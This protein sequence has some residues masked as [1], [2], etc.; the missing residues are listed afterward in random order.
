[1]EGRAATIIA[2]SPPVSWRSFSEWQ[3]LLNAASESPPPSVRPFSRQLSVINPGPCAVTGPLLT[4]AGC[5]K[6]SV[7][8]SLS[9]A[10]LQPAVQLL[11]G[12]S[13]PSLRHTFFFFRS[14]L[15]FSTVL[16][17]APSASQQASYVCL[18]SLSV[19]PLPFLP[20]SNRPSV[21]AFY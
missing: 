11:L 10:Q 17:S 2:V 9:R 13:L 14:F 15:H 8:H 6:T 5:R 1:M 4:A 21:S 20:E 12:L 18:A 16:T 19:F 3:L 7:F